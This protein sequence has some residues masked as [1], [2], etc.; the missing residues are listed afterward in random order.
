[1]NVNSTIGDIPLLWFGAV[2]TSD[3]SARNQKIYVCPE[4]RLCEDI[5]DNFRLA[6]YHQ[7]D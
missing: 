2:Q 5:C 4:A 1:M 7:F 6:E 3:P